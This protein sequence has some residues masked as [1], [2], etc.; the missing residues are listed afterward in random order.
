MQ[1]PALEIKVVFLLEGGKKGRTR[2]MAITA[3]PGYQDMH[4][5]ELTE[6]FAWLIPLQ[7]KSWFSQQESFAFIPAVA[8][9][10]PGA[11]ARFSWEK[12]TFPRLC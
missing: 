10:K 7:R 12:E 5:G 9:L 11:C 1:G 8:S 3:S 2:L 4:T 6:C